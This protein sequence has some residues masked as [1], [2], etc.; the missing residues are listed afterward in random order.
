MSLF[1][2]FFPVCGL[3]SHFLD[4]VFN[5]AKVLIFIKSSLSVISFMD[6]AFGVMF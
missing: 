6:L 1:K 2:Y 5:R 3:S 4:S